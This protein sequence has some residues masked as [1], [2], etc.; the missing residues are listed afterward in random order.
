MTEILPAS[1]M[2]S[3]DVIARAAEILRGGGLVAFPTETVYGLGAN[4][5]DA[6]AV[7]R[8]FAAKGRPPNN[9]VIVHVASIAEARALAE[10][11][12]SAADR[13]AERFWP[14]PLTLVV[15]KRPHVPAIVTGG[16]PTVGVRLPGHP[17]AR[18]L[19]AAAGLPVAAPSA[20]RS[21]SIS[22]TTAEHVLKDL[23]GRIDAVLDG[24][25][26]TG[27]LESTV[28]DL[29]TEIATL[30]RPGLVAPTEIE[31]IIGPI[32]QRR[33]DAPIEREAPLPAPGQFP[34][35]YA[36]RAAMQCAA[37]GHKLAARLAAEGVRVGRLV[38]DARPSAPS[39]IE[40]LMPG[41]PI[42]YA[43]QLYSALHRLDDLGVEQIVVDLP[44]DTEPWLAI[45]DRLRRG[46]LQ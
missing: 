10:E 39:A 23:T 21:N 35:H 20:N 40:I 45:R 13:L 34:R 19:I 33:A 12:P 3:D 31:Q 22:P 16:G 14:G 25:P 36:P 29:S 37:E 9:P 15:R 41:E 11:W 42:E 43:A 7:A 6:A 27:G 1:E 5:L 44:P 26:T 8:I 38:L 28:L 18:Q 32:V 2:F 4:A 46:S 30:L 17:L 24:G